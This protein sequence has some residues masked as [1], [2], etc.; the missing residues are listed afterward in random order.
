MTFSVG[1]VGPG[2]MGYQCWVVLRPPDSRPKVFARR[3]G[4]ADQVAG[5]GA[6]AVG[7]LA[8]PAGLDVVIVCLFSEGQVDAERTRAV[9][10][11]CSRRVW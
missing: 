9:C 1:F 8:E 10:F 5:L 7:S 4:V 2:R 6:S 11:R 3:S